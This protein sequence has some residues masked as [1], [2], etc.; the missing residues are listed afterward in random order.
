MED[1]LHKKGSP[2]GLHR[3]VEVVRIPIPDVRTE[4]VD[5]LKHNIEPRP[6]DT[7]LGLLDYV[8]ERATTGHNYLMK[9]QYGRLADNFAQQAPFILE[10][11]VFI[12]QMEM[13]A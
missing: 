9:A 12:N 7:F 3:Y 4:I 13:T 8:D 6:G 5:F 2:V 1:R 11:Q 10:G